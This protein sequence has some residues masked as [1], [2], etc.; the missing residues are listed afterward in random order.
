MYVVRRRRGRAPCQSLAACSTTHRLEPRLVP[1]TFPRF[2][3][4]AAVTITGG[5]C[6]RLRNDFVEVA[7]FA[8][9]AIC[10]TRTDGERLVVVTDADGAR[11]YQSESE[12]NCPV[13]PKM[14]LELAPGAGNCA[15]SGLCEWTT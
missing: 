2:G 6:M 1:S 4:E 11:R 12:M 8:H 9:P 10:S 13:A 15:A 5:V 7:G 3:N 14:T